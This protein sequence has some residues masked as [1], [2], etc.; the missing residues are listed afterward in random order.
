MSLDHFP[1]ITYLQTLNPNVK[2]LFKNYWIEHSCIYDLI[3]KVWGTYV[4]GDHI[5]IISKNLIFIK[6]ALKLK[7][8]GTGFFNS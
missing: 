2:I 6:S 3:K 5:Y 7:N 4:H 1:L 8:W